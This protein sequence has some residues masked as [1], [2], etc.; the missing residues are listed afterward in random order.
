VI[1]KA[2]YLRTAGIAK[3]TVTGRRKN[4]LRGTW[5]ITLD[6]IKTNGLVNGYKKYAFF[7]NLP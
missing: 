7:E 5:R 2:L 4:R 3:K 6:I 1:K